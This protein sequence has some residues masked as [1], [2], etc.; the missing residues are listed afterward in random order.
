MTGISE[1]DNRCPRDSLRC[2]SNSTQSCY[3]AEMQYDTLMGDVMRGFCCIIPFLNAIM[4]PC[5]SPGEINR[6]M[7]LKKGD[8]MHYEDK[9][10]GFSFDLPEGWRHDEHNLTLTFF[11]P[12]GRIGYPFELIQ[13][14]IGTILPRYLD[15]ESR[16][17]FLAEP[18]A[19]VL[20]SRLGNER[21]VVVLRKASETEI[22]AVH[23]GV[24][25]TIAHSN[26]KATKEAVERLKESFGFPSVEEAV[27]AI[28][29]SNDPQKHAIL[30]ALR[31]GSPG[32]ARRVLR[33]AGAAS[34]DKR[35]EA[36][37]RADS[38]G[39][40]GYF[41]A[42]EVCAMLESRPEALIECLAGLKNA[43]DGQSRLGAGDPRG[44]LPV[45]RR[46]HDRF[47]G[48]PD[49]RLLLGI[50]KADLAAAYGNIGEYHKAADFAEDAIAIVEGVARLA[51]TE[52]MARM[53]LATSRGILGQ[54][55]DSE[56]EFEKAEAILR[57]IPGAGTH[58]ERL[59]LIRR[60]VRNS[61][62]KP[63]TRSG[64]RWIIGI[65]A[66][67]ALIAAI[68]YLLK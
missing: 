45:L 19:E 47:E 18:G 40:G 31:S 50:S 61:S 53:S 34:S 2:N 57:R 33:E 65:L 67:M 15:P 38:I 68:V 32:Q 30:R 17:K 59:E 12:N 24:Q 41:I 51:F 11:G 52:A 5:F 35:S 28:Q 42:T 66:A 13:M 49:A 46:A 8:H 39:Q 36:P 23:D 54:A 3:S 9:S 29:R 63:R 44:A 56:R 43:Q 26:D 48:I 4:K 64:F 1:R 14:Q 62:P 22:S 20:R 10:L 60:N 7:P 16:E 6:F 58:L 27:A 55:G 21:N 25:Y 37:E